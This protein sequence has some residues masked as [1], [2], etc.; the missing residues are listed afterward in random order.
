MVVEHTV[1]VFE[2]NPRIDEIAIVS[3]PM[4]MC[5]FENFVL[6]NKWRKV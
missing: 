2:R 3:N 5:D 4:L 1:D 6:R